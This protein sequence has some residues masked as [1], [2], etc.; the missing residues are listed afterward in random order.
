MNQGYQV[1]ALLKGG[2]LEKVSIV[3]STAPP[4]QLAFHGLGLPVRSYEA[5]D[6]FEALARLRA[7]LADHG[8]RLLCAG[9]RFDVFPSAMARE[10]GGGR[11]AYVLEPGQPARELL[12]IFA[13]APREKLGSVED[14]R[15]YH[16]R[17]WESLGG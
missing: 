5:S 12:D 15:A 14:Q 13:A 16:A 4:W 7:D 17:W 8:V 6:L 10:M 9:A 2:A 3:P 11:M 1:E